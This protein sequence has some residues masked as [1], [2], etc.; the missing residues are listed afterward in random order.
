MYANDDPAGPVEYGP[1]LMVQG[2]YQVVAVMTAPAA[3]ADDPVGYAV[4][5]SAGG[6]VRREL[7][8][9]DAKRWATELAE[10]EREPQSP[11][12]TPPATSRKRR[13]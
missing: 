9:D 3:L 5:T 8:L 2:R 6:L 11:R 12:P 13:R 7:T 1:V 4:L 10:T